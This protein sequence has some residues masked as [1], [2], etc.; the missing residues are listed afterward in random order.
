MAEILDDLRNNSTFSVE[1]AIEG[2]I[3]LLYERQNGQITAGVAGVVRNVPEHEFT[4]KC[5][6]INQ[7]DQA[8]RIDFTPADGET[9]TLD[10]ENTSATGISFYA[11]GQVDRI[12][13]VGADP[14]SFGWVLDFESLPLHN[15]E[16]GV[17]PRKFRSTF[18]INAGEFYAHTVSQNHL[19][20]REE[21]KPNDPYTL[22]GKVATVVGVRRRLDQAGSR[23]RLRVGSVEITAAQG[24]RLLAVVS[25]SCPEAN[26]LPVGQRMGHANHYYKALGHKLEWGERKLFS[27]T[28]LNVSNVGGPIS[29]EASCL[30]GQ[31]TRSNP[32][33]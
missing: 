18:R 19:L 22:V 4:V 23:A 21:G 12:C 26:Q 7:N 8:Q 25:L 33:G 28:K 3:A 29:P 13:G 5:L 6:K 14:K 30:L 20:V 10:I 2:I 15:K 11:N 1:V 27:S 16:V 32:N 17:D 9:L 31:G 24:E